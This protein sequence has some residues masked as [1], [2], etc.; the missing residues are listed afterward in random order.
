MAGTKK[1]VTT[2]M[3][4]AEKSALEMHCYR[5]ATNLAYSD[6]IKQ[7]KCVRD[8]HGTVYH[9]IQIQIQRLNILYVHKPSTDFL[10]MIKMANTFANTAQRQ[11]IFGKFFKRDIIKSAGKKTK[12]KEA[13]ACSKEE[14]LGSI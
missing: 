5:H 1:G 14:N 10:D 8:V 13:E 11:S 7:V 6:S 4:V 12:G 9:Q 2:L 3:K